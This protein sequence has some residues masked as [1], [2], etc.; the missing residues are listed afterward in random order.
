MPRL[1]QN[2]TDA[3]HTRFRAAIQHQMVLYGIDCLTD[4]ADRCGMNARTL[5]RK[6]KDPE[7][8]SSGELRKLYNVLRCTD[9]QRLI[10]TK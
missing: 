4:L 10:L 9:E 5:Y 3:R 2:P 1:K 6:M 8:F 7:G